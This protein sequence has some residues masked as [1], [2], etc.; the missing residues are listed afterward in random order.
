MLS[1]ND[2]K[3]ILKIPSGKCFIQIFEKIEMTRAKIAYLAAILK[4]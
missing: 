4:R 1:Y 2:P 3:F